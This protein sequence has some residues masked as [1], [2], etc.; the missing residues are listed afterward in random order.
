[1]VKI[2]DS[3]LATWLDH[4]ALCIPILNIKEEERKKKKLL[5]QK[6]ETLIQILNALMIYPLPEN[7]DI[8]DAMC[9]C[10]KSL[11]KRGTKKRKKSKCET[12]IQMISRSFPPVKPP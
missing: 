10:E 12:I 11:A 7:C 4:P 5:S 2:Y 6:V 9:K 3:L 8:V 1:M